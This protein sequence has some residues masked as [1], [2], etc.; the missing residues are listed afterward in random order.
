MKDKM[1]IVPGTFVPYND[2]VTLLSYKRLRNLDLDMDV[3]CFKGKEDKGLL[4]ELNNDECFKKFN[5]KYTNDLDWAIARNHPLRLPMSLILMNKYIED[6]LKEFEKKDY[7]YLFTSIAP[8][9]SHICGKR[10]KKKHPDVI[11]YASFSDPFK[12]SPYKK[13]DL[14]NRSIFYKFVYNVGAWA[15]YNNKY[16]EAAIY[17]ADKLIFICEEQRDYT[18]SQYPDLDKKELLNKSIIMPLTY[19]PTWDM[20]KNLLS[21]NNKRNKPLQAVHLGRLYGL[22]KIDTFLEALKELKEEDDKLEKKIVF[23][24]YSEIQAPDIKKIKEYGLENLFILHDKVSYDE[25]IKIMQNADVL[26]LFDSL[27]TKEKL[28]P[29]LPSKI[30]EYLLLK[31]PILAICDDN[32]PSYRILKEYGFNTMG[33]E[34][35]AIKSNIKY[36]INND[37]N[38]DYSLDKLDC[39]NYHLIEENNR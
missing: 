25:S 24:Q 29:Y 39:N 36:I 2:T 8:G 7:K 13:A 18:I 3:F 14:D 35:E 23:H 38:N 20:Y 28:Q 1:F 4:N 31:K 17:N 30:V 10:I 34:V 16:E 26:V 12:N 5:I 15:L 27:M 6:S 19:I 32:S 11:W 21:K 33:S 9:I 37:F 22:R